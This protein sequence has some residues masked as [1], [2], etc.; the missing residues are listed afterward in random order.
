[1]ITG[2]VSARREALIVATVRDAAGKEH[3][4]EAAVDTGFDGWLS[5]PPGFVA[6]LGLTWQ[7]FGRALLADGS[8]TVFDIY[9]ATVVWDGQP[10]VIPVYEM[11][12]QP[13]V[14]ISLMYG[15]ELNLP[16]LDGAAFTLQS[17]PGP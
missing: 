7:R 16:I 12:A 3:D 8:E 11:D 17:I 15:Y 4:R 9:E 14:G 5:L 2:T 1:M 6:A 10:G 13:L